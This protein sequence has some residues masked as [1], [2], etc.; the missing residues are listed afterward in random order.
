MFFVIRSHACSYFF[1][2]KIQ[3]KQY[4]VNK[5]LTGQKTSN[6]P[7]KEGNVSNGL[8]YMNVVYKDDEE[9]WTQVGSLRLPRCWYVPAIIFTIDHYFQSAINEIAT[10]PVQN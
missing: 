6:R 9:K 5:F 2:P 8:T 7:H 10:N 1:V 4:Y 3:A